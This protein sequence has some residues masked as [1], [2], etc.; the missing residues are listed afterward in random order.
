MERLDRRNPRLFKAVAS[1][2]CRLFA[3]TAAVT[4]LSIY[5]GNVSGLTNALAS[6]DW[7]AL[8][9]PLG[10]RIFCK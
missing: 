10:S 9:Y 4:Y 5:K 6:F 7:A 3:V 2:P 1:L 8:T